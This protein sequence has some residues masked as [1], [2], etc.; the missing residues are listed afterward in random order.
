MQ[1]Q[2]GG[3]VIINIGSVSGMRPTPMTM[4]YGAAKAGLVNITE[5]LAVEW[6]PKVRVV[7]V[8]S[9]LGRRRR[10]RRGRARLRPDAHPSTA[11]GALDL[12]RRL[13][14]EEVLR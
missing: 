10:R 7:G 9:R 3:G 6:A 12:I 14:L 4:A 2:E 1:A 11:L 13:A 8:A 5:T